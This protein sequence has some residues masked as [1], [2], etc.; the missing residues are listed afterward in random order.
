MHDK[1]TKG[2]LGLT[3]AI[4]RL[5]ELEWHV[6]L[7][8]SEHM[9]YDLIAEKDGICKRVQVRYT[10]PKNNRLNIKLSTS[11]SDKNGCHTKTRNVG[12]FDVLASFNPETKEVYFIN[13]NE[14]KNSRMITIR[15]DKAKNGQEKR[16]RYAKDYYS[17]DIT[18]HGVIV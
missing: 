13:D 5:T 16:I 15:F 12:D 17:I 10:T 2:D 9:S 3:Y 6:S 8:I 14:F 7:P 4:A 18:P 11:W 1:K